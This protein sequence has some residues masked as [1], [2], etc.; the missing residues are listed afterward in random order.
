MNFY[1][2]YIQIDQNDR[3]MANSSQPALIDHPLMIRI[4]NLDDVQLGQY[5]NRILSTPEN[6]VFQDEPVE[7]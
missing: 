1:Y 6:P 2:Y 5:Y 3:A 7:E 4:N